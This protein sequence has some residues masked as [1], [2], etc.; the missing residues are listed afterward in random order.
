MSLE[1]ASGREQ[2]LER[3][4]GQLSVPN[5]AAPYLRTLRQPPPS[6]TYCAKVSDAERGPWKFLYNRLT[7]TQCQNVRAKQS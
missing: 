5:L 3:D 6:A 4:L 1:E 7:I 2:S